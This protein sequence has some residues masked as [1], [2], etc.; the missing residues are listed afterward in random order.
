MQTRSCRNSHVVVGVENMKPGTKV[1]IGYYLSLK[2]HQFPSHI[3]HFIYYCYPLSGIL[4]FLN[5]P[6]NYPYLG[7][8]NP[9]RPVESSVE[10]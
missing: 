4:K 10:I 6:S 7:S 8:T 5:E 1:I 2:K 3:N 9:I